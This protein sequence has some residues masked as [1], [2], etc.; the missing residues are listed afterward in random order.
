MNTYSI[1]TFLLLFW[2][3]S[4]GVLIASAV[5]ILKSKSKIAIFLSKSTK[6]E[7]VIFAKLLLRFFL[8]QL[9]DVTGLNDLTI[10]IVI[11]VLTHVGVS[12][13][14]TAFTAQ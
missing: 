11:V 5:T 7:I 6:I 14:P 13:R 12:C 10:F 3:A 4:P 2:Q 8:Q 9:M 1:Y